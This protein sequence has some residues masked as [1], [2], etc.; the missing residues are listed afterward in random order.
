MSLKHLIRAWLPWIFEFIMLVKLYVFPR[1]TP[2]AA[3]TVSLNLRKKYKTKVTYYKAR[4]PRLFKSVKERQYYILMHNHI[5]DRLEESYLS[6]QSYRIAYRFPFF[7]A[8]LIEYYYSLPTKFKNNHGYGRWIFRKAMEDLVPRDICWQRRKE[9]PVIPYGL[10][11]IQQDEIKFRKLINESR[12]QNNYHY[13]DYEK[14]NRILNQIMNRNKRAKFFGNLMIFR[15][16]ISVLILQK[17]QREG[18]IDIG[19][20][21]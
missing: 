14:L 4:K 21:C 7:D 19:I 8:K 16:S 20:K 10:Y 2:Y 18:K 17:W 15:N 3:V 13:I 12:S 5:P 11:L 9:G 6:T 1:C